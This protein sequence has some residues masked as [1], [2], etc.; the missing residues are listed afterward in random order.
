MNFFEHQDAARRRTVLLV[1]LFVLAI[2]GIVL[3]TYAALAFGL[4]V[5]KSGVSAWNVQTFAL[6]AVAV[7]LLVASASGYKMA[8][9]RGSGV[10]VAELMG[11]RELSS[12]T[13]D[14]AEQRLMNV[15]SEMAIASGVPM[16]IVYVLDEEPGINAFAAGH[17]P[18]DA[19]VAVTAGALQAFNRDELQGV[20]A[21]EFSHILNRDVRLN[22]RLTGLVFGILVLA[23]SGR[24]LLQIFGRGRVRSNDKGGNALLVVVL[25]ALALMIVGYIGLFFGKLIKQAVSRQREF[26]ADASAVQFTRNPDGLASALR[27]IAGWSSG[28][29][30][31]S[32]SAEEISHFFFAD[33]MKSSFFA[34]LLSTHPPL[35]ERIRRIDPSFDASSL[36][37]SRAQV[38][39]PED[40]NDASQIAALTDTA[41]VAARPE[42]VVAS[43]GT[44]EP[45]RFFYDDAL[46]AEIP[47]NLRASISS[48]LGATAVVYS[49]LIDS[50]KE[51]ATRQL[52]ALEENT[53][54]LVMDE[55][56]KTLP[57]VQRVDKFARLPLIDSAMPALR[58]LT[59]DQYESFAANLSRLVNADHHLSLFEFA[60]RSVVSNRLEVHFGRRSKVQYRRSRP[61]EIRHSA[62]LLSALARVGTDDIRDQERAFRAGASRLPGAQISELLSPTSSDIEG[63]IGYL[64]GIS[65]AR[66]QE[67]VDACAYCVLSDEDVTINEA[68]LLRIV[69]IALG[70]P[71]P[72][73]LPRLG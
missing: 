40:A 56:K 51:I 19:V 71:L 47:T 17:G 25:V 6:V 26:L 73:F 9:L 1:V 12:L 18:E 45:E 54:H 61:N 46:V 10:K 72:P 44:T 67:V 30:I 70:C 21:H 20:I 5:S 23:V 4:T 69:I 63:A 65:E 62:V 38:L 55:V 35:A 16:P 64:S 53:P 48:S 43:V 41:R 11:G 13:D 3:T 7:S 37:D 50:D 14:P 27:K 15:V 24:I 2:V 28:S 31:Q 8:S 22:T 29:Q 66:R 57:V 60:V 52:H 33:G 34:S 32:A 59:G 49:L 68:E 36:P 58:S 42:S 39:H